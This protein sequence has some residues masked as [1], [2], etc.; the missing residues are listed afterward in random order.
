MKNTP[1]SKTNRIILI[2]LIGFITAFFWYYLKN[3]IVPPITDKVITPFHWPISIF[4]DYYSINN[5]FNQW[6][7]YGEYNYLTGGITL[8]QILK[9]VSLGNPYNASKVILLAYF[10]F[11]S[12][13]VFKMTKNLSKNIRYLA[14]VVLVFCNYPILF[15]VHTANF[16]GFVLILLIFSYLFYKKN[17]INITFILIGV[18]GAIKIFPLFI[19]FAYVKKENFLISIKYTSLGFFLAFISPFIISLIYYPNGNIIDGFWGWAE[20]ISSG[21]A[22]QMYKDTMVVGYNG[23]FFGHSLL[24]SIRLIMTPQESMMFSFMTKYY[25]PILFISSFLILISSIISL[26]IK[27]VLHRYIFILSALCLFRPTSTDYYLIQ[28][29]VPFIALMVSDSDSKLD[30]KLLIGITILFLSKNY[31]LFY[32]NNYITSNTI[33]NSLV[34]L[35]LYLVI[36]INPINRINR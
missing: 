26:K 31:Y 23:V 25:G 17:K 18:A 27:S 6:G 21:R 30:W 4:C 19:W 12:F 13:Y 1:E 20:T 7:F 29:F 24:N 34:L 32:D 9:F 15:V 33:I 35:F 16:E 3:S 36:L 2:M 14:T 11:S 10:F 5:T 28:F 22:M 8:L